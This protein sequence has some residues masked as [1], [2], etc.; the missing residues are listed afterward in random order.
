MK[1][2]ESSNPDE[3][4]AALRELSV[5]PQHAADIASIDYW[6]LHY[7]NIDRVYH[8][9]FKGRFIS[10]LRKYVAANLK[11]VTDERQAYQWMADQLGP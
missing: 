7:D 6:I 2:S 5:D 9:G 4:Q 11:Y 10:N 8:G 1:L 3:L